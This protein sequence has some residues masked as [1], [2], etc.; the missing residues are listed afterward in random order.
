[1]GEWEFEIMLEQLLGRDLSAGT[2]AF[3]ESLLERC[4]EVLDAGEEG[5]PIDDADLELLAAAGDLAAQG[6]DEE[7][8]RLD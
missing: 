6:F 1:M 2:E 5:M 8:T 3:R 7:F 4:L